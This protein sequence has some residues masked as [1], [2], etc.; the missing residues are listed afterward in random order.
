MSNKDEGWWETV[1]SNE[2]AKNLHNNWEFV[3]YNFGGHNLA[4][5][6]TGFGDGTYATYVGYDANGKI[7]RLLTDFGLVIWWEKK[8]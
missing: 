6:S 4:C 2:A 5:F 1:F 3:V 8:K 7:C